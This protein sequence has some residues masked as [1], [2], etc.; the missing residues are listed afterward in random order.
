ME[1]VRDR[2]GRVGRITGIAEGVAAA[3]R[4][5]QRGR[6][7]RVVLYDDRGH[8]RL[9][10]ADA[11]AFE[12][13]VAAAG[14]MSELWEG[15]SEPAATSSAEQRGKP[16]PGGVSVPDPQVGKRNDKEARGGRRDQS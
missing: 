11:S 16:S 1:A 6:A 3:A 2:R 13:L 8:P 4:R 5:R 10:P 12:D 9:L 15:R 7:P 14:R